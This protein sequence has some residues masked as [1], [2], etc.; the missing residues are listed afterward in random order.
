MASQI[1]YAQTYQNGSLIEPNIALNDATKQSKRSR[2][3]P[4]TVFAGSPHQLEDELGTKRRFAGGYLCIYF[5]Y[6]TIC[7]VDAQLDHLDAQA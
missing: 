4:R 2:G 5:A 7:N 3:N 1:S 6:D